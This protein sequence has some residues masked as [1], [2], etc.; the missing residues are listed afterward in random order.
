MSTRRPDL[1]AGA[2]HDGRAGERGHGEQGLRDGF[3][4]QQPLRALLA[5][6]AQGA[7]AR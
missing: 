7:A 1:G 2:V 6:L 3:E 5:A 4:G